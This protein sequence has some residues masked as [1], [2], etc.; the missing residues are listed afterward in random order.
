M[1]VSKCFWLIALPPAGALRPS[2]LV[3]E[4]S[5]RKVLRE[6]LDLK[7]EFHSSLKGLLNSKGGNSI[8]IETG[9]IYNCSAEFID[10][11]TTQELPF[12]CQVF[13][14]LHKDK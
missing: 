2:P 10:Q 9:A 6:T 7:M 13:N 12:K 4:G 14:I 8:T 3:S 5:I 11:E 1:T